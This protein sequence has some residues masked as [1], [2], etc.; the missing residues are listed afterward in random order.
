MEGLESGA[1]DY[2]TKPFSILGLQARAKALLR[3]GALNRPQAQQ[4][5]RLHFGWFYTSIPKGEVLKEKITQVEF[6][7]IDVDG[8]RST[9]ASSATSTE[10]HSIVRNS[11]E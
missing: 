9:S 4:A 5:T 11:W 2:L 1:D 8:I 7:H 10:K 3:R 6:D